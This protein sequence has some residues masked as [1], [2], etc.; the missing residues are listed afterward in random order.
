MSRALALLRP[1]EVVTAHE[2]RR[3][4]HVSRPP[5]WVRMVSRLYQGG[6]ITIA[7]LMHEYGVSLAT[8]RRDIVLLAASLPLVSD[9]REHVT[10]PLVWR[11]M[12]S[13]P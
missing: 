3:H 7:Y 11:L 8:A 4:P 13:A 10:D 6:T 2:K 1:V 12:R 5:R 9:K